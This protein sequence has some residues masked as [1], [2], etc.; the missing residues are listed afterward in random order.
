MSIYCLY[1]G[2][3]EASAHSGWEWYADSVTKVHYIR[4]NR[5]TAEGAS[6]MDRDKEVL[7]DGM[8]ITTR[9]A[10]KVTS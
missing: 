2:P 1:W 5:R 4:F 3:F 8:T 9:L 7:D 10:L 6:K